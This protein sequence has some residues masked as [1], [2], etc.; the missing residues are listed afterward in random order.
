MRIPLVKFWAVFVSVSVFAVMAKADSLTDGKP[1]LKITP[2]KPPLAEGF[3]LQDVRL[4]PGE[5]WTGQAIATNYLSSLDPD[6]LLA[7]FRMEAGLPKKAEIYG[8]WEER[9]VAGHSLGHYLT[10]CSLAWAATGDPEFQRRVNYIVS[11]LAACQKAEGDGY[12]A[13]FPGGRKAFAEIA[14]GDIRSS[15]FDLNGLWVPNY[16]FHKELAGM[17]DAYRYAANQQ[18]LEVECKFAD[19]LNQVYSGLT[20]EQMQQVLACEH[21]GMNEVLAD[22]YAD[23]GNE[24]YLKLAQKF[25]HDAILDPLAKGQDILPG[26]HANTQV[27]KLIGLATLYELTGNPQD[28]LAAQ[29][30]WDRV[31]YHHSYVTGGNCDGEHFGEPDHLNDRLSAN[32]TETCNVNNM[33]KL[34]EHIFGWSAS[35][36]AAD[37]Y[38]RALLNDIRSTQNPD[39]CVIYNLSL[40]PGYHKDYQSLTNS[41][42]CCVGTGMENHVKYGEG[43][44]FHNASN[45][46]V[47]LFIAS[48]LHW[49]TR[50]VTLRQETQWPDSDQSKI[51]ITTDQPQEFSLN[52]R[53]PSWADT[54]TVKVNGKIVSQFTS[55]SSYAEIRREWK[56]GDTVEIS[57]PMVLRTEAMPDNPNRIAIFY[58]PTLLAAVLGPQ[59]DPNANRVDYVP[60]ILTESKPVNDW[61]KPV[62]LKDLTFKTV[63]VGKPRDVQLVPFNTIVNQRYTV[64]LDKFTPEDWAKRQDEIRATEKK[65]MELDARTVDFFQPGEMQPERDHNVQGEKSDA[66]EALGRKLRHAYDGG[67]FTFDMKV[68]PAATNE[69]VCTWWGDES[70]ERNFDIL[71]DGTKIASQK[72]LHNQPGKFWDATYL[73]PTELTK[74]KPKVTVKLQAQPG[75]FAGGL[76]GSRILRTPTDSNK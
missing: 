29:F 17:R 27:P 19:W 45:L 70:G 44:Y 7:G 54:L 36:R 10:G 28:R 66:V 67:W 34:T 26:K 2:A 39:G 48:E 16:T 59:N 4:L 56:N 20:H 49:K 31:V 13:A 50:G 30:F 68:D 8:G 11:E 18:A 5:F 40:K 38:E 64:Y 24:R 53:H 74:G 1:P 57:F 55:P 58:G 41:F 14:K 51:I 6:R 33:L 9:G 15:G 69:L 43:I 35:A 3:N 60:V 47:N 52:I 42:T 23:T 12:L 65:Q 63:G 61:V 76:F 73:I 46:W 75:N 62:S 32:T 21:G 25:H 37:F 71:V 22:L 72:L